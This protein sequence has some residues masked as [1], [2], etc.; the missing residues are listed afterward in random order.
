MA[1]DEAQSSSKK[2]TDVGHEERP[3]SAQDDGS[4]NPAGYR[5]V[6]NAGLSGHRHD[7]TLAVRKRD[8]GRIIGDEDRTTS[9]GHFEGT[10]Q[11]D[12]ACTCG[13]A[14]TSIR[15][16]EHGTYERAARGHALVHPSRPA[17]ID[18]D[19]EPRDLRDLEVGLRGRLRHSCRSLH[20]GHRWR[21]QRW[22]ETHRVSHPQGCAVRVKR[23]EATARP[24]RF[25]PPAD[26]NG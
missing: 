20:L 8:R 9:G 1:W 12:P 3:A 22:L 17:P 15:A 4:I 19:G 10:G 23:F 16:G 2:A 25:H 5:Q 18:E 21:C 24:N 14:R 13:V 7:M 11:L 6:A 26:A